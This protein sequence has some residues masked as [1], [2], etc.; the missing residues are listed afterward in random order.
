MSED[1]SI[2]YQQNLRL[3]ALTGERKVKNLFMKHIGNEVASSDYEVGN[4]V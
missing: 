4:K 3:K 2:F 1:G